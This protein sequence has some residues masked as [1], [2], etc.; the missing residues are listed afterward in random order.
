MSGKLRPRLTR[1]LKMNKYQRPP[2][3][4]YGFANT[5]N[6]DL[7]FIRIPKNASGTFVNSLQIPNYTHASEL[8]YHKIFCALRDPIE[9]F[10][11]SVAETCVRARLYHEVKYYGDIVVDPTIYFRLQ[12]SIR[13]NSIDELLLI[14][15]DTID[16]LGPFDAHHERQ[17]RFVEDFIN[18][19]LNIS[20]FD[21]KDINRI[22]SDLMTKY[23]GNVM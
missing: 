17:V 15:L 14:I 7:A 12:T 1:F 13:E 19:D 21:V 23:K 3:A 6:S 20:F 10:Y 18:D 4:S 16:T 9:R 8:S 11:S 2:F 5:G 22:I